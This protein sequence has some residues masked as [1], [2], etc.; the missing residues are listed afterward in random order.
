MVNGG[1]R[2]GVLNFF[3]LSA[4]HCGEVLFQFSHGS[5]VYSHCG[6]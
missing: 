2:K 5:V 6:S 3:R 1:R 4:G